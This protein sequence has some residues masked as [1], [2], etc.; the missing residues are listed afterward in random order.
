MRA[1]PILALAL[2]GAVPAAAETPVPV[3]AFEGVSLIGGGEVRLRHGPVQKVTLLR[4]DLAVS[5][6]AIENDKSL[7]IRAC[8]RSC[9]NVELLVEVV[10]PDIEAVAI[11]GGG[12]VAAGPGFPASRHLAASVTGGGTLDLDSLPANHV[13][14]SIRGGGLIRTDA[15]GD[16]AV[17]ILG[18]GNVTYLRDPRT[19]VS[20]N[21]GGTV[22][23]AAR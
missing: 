12:T 19:T 13:A 18:G 7:V 22:R 2:A 14:A 17:S 8:R 3:G 16:L 21:G 6:I 1:L 20:I 10:T 4:G 9:R 23:K 15:T 5:S 11:T